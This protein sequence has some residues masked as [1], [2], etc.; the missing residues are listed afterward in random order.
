MMHFSFYEKL[1]EVLSYI[2]L[3]TTNKMERYAVEAAYYD[4][5]ETR[6]F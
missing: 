4:H 5:F 1:S 2:L 6:A 3:S